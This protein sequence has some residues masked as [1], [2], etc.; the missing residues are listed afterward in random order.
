MKNV[1]NFEKPTANITPN[2]G[3]VKALSLSSGTRKG[4]L[5]I[6]LFLQWSV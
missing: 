3:K 2:G 4:H 1:K 6:H 5:Y